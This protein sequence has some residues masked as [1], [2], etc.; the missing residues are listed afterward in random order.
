MRRAILLLL[1]L[2]LTAPVRA[3]IPDAMLSGLSWRLVGP[4]RAGWATVAVGDPEDPRTFYFGAAGGGVWK[5]GDA[6]R[7]WRSVFDDRP[8]SIGALAVAPSAPQ[9]LYV[10]TGQVTSRYDIAAGA[11]VFRSRD[12]G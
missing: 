2:L 6:G 8:A 12:G 9:T 5:S 1:P 3:E 10:G 4:F 7:T 11:G